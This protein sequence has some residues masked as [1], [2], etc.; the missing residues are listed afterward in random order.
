MPNHECST[1]AQDCPRGHK[2][3]PWANDGGGAWNATRCEPLVKEPR[4]VGQRCTAS[5]GGLPGQDECDGTSICW[6]IDPE[7]N[8]DR[9]VPFCIGTESSPA[10]PDPCDRCGIFDA[11]GLCFSPCDPLLQDCKPGDACIPLHGRPVCAPEIS[12]E[13]TGIGDPCPAAN[14]CPPGLACQRDDVVPGCLD[15]SC[16]TPYCPLDGV[17][18]CPELLPGTT[19]TPVFDD[20]PQPG[21]AGAPTGLCLGR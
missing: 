8:A 6:D 20:W 5:R 2:C 15:G 4:G 17:D 10:C 12:D 18:P 1:F 16:C 9:C 14:G 13:G 7:T 3:M 11:V 19:C 21:C